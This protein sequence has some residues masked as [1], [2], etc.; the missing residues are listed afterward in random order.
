MIRPPPMPNMPARSRRADR[1]EH[2]TQRSASAL[3]PRPEL[4]ESARPV[5][6]A[7]VAAPDL[8]RL[9]RS[10]RRDRGDPRERAACGSRRRSSTVHGWTE[11][12]AAAACASSAGR[13]EVPLA[14]RSRRRAERAASAG[15]APAARPD[16]RRESSSRSR[17]RPRACASGTRRRTTPRGSGRRRRRRSRA[18]RTR[19]AIVP[20]CMPG[21][22][23][24]LDD[25]AQRSSR[26]GGRPA[27]AAESGTRRT[28]TGS[29]ASRSRAR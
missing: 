5:S 19:R 8:E 29:R 10:V 17:A 16:D 25:V 23:L 6:W 15:P 13:D 7:S 9:V 26:S 1:C 20:C 27:R 3:R 2:Q 22:A 24:D 21:A 28:R 4:P 18:S 12:S 11:R 14:G